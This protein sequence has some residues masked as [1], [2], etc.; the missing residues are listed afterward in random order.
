MR[1][2]VHAI[3]MRTTIDKEGIAGHIAAIIAAEKDRH[4]TDIL[5]GIT[6]APH[7]IGLGYRSRI[8]R[9]GSGK[10]PI[11]FTGRPGQITLQQI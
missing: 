7:G 2:P 1:F 11:G 6:N 5:Q 3:D 9:A 8:V 10:A 4:R